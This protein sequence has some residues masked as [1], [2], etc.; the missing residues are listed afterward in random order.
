MSDIERLEN[1][2]SGSNMTR[3]D[4]QQ[5]LKDFY[6]GLLLAILSSFFI[7]T[8][9]IFKKLGLIRL[10]KQTSNRAGENDL[11]FAILCHE[12]DKCS[13]QLFYFI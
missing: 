7:G 3:K 1:I 5:D 12:L 9:F 8:S 11:R 2:T 4:V 13:H 10:A 6:I